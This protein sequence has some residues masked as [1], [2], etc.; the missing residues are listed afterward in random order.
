MPDAI[1]IQDIPSQSYFSYWQRSQHICSTMLTVQMYQPWLKSTIPRPSHC[2]LAQVLF[3]EDGAQ[4]L[5]A[6]AGRALQRHPQGTAGERSREGGRPA[7]AREDP[8]ECPG[9]RRGQGNA[10]R[11]C[12]PQGCARPAEPCAVPVWATS[13]GMPRPCLPCARIIRST[14]HCCACAEG[15]TLPNG[16]VDCKATPAPQSLMQRLSG[17]HV[18]A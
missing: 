1:P 16:A 6:G 18:Q 5:L 17:Q 3:A 13:A 9:R 11:R 15:R 12:Q 14:L 7:A 8:P 4:L 10:Q 2:S